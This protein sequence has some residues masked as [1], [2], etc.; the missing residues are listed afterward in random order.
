MRIPEKQEIVVRDTYTLMITVSLSKHVRVVF[1]GYKQ[2]RFFITYLLGWKDSV[3]DF[4]EDRLPV[5]HRS[6]DG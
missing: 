1:R 6:A 2:H 4:F 5:T 3:P